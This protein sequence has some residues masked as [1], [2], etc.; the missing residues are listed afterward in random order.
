[1]EFDIQKLSACLLEGKVTELSSHTGKCL[2]L[3]DKW[4]TGGQTV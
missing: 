3:R 2:H 4:S 1:M